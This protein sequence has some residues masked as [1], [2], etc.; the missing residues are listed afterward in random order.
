MDKKK[1]CLDCGFLTI[2]GFEISRPERIM[3]GTHGQSAVMPAHS[4]QTR[5]FK[6]LWI[7]DLIYSGDTF[8]GVI[9]EIERNRDDCP[10]FLPY[11]AGLTPAQHLE[12]QLEKRKEKLQ[13]RIAKLGFWGA[14]FGG[15]VGTLLYQFFNWLIKFIF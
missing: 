7:Y 13:W 12:S 11:E 3:L 2:H 1:T 6:N 15:I 4:E 9:E 8:N 14:L 5:C 10:G